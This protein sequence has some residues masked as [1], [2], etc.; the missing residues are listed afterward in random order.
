MSSG[1][2]AKINY[3]VLIGAV[4]GSRLV[5]THARTSIVTVLN[6][7]GASSNVVECVTRIV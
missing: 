2:R 4:G 7:I 5:I 6:E 3:S 1:V